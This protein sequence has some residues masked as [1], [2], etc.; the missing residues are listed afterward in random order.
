M[1]PSLPSGV[2]RSEDRARRPREA[3][4]IPSGGHTRT[5][6]RTAMGYGIPYRILEKPHG[7]TRSARTCTLPVHVAVPFGCHIHHV[8]TI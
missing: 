8:E 2:S 6:G 7:L 5:G 1:L 3:P 4:F